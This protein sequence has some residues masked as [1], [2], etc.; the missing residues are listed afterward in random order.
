MTFPMSTPEI[1]HRRATAC[2]DLANRAVSAALTLADLG[3]AEGAA[4]LM[5]LADVCRCAEMA[6]AEKSGIA[7][8][9]A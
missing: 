7:E 9:S 4:E 1:Y 6:A 5:A 3:D 8:A 2:R